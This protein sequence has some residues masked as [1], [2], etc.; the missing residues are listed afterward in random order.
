MVGLVIL[1]ACLGLGYDS[2][3]LSLPDKDTPLDW[4]YPAPQPLRIH[5]VR[6]L[7]SREYRL[8]EAVAL[9]GAGFV[10]DSWHSQGLGF[11]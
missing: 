7:W 9:A 10:T 1:A 8:E 4:V 2:P 11:G 5:I 6:G 3:A